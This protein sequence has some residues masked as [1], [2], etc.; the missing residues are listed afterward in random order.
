MN[1]LPKSRDDS[2]QVSIRSYYHPDYWS[3]YNEAQTKEKRL[4]YILLRELCDTIIEPV[5][6]N[7]RKPISVSD[8]IFCMGLK[9]YNNVSSRRVS[10]DL[11]HAQLSGFISRTPH[12]NTLMS[13]MNNKIAEELLQRLITLSA[14]P[15]KSL[16]TDFAVD[17]TGFS[18]QRYARWYQFRFK[19]GNKIT[20]ISPLKTKKMWVK[21]HVCVGTKT[22]IIT[23]AVVTFDNGADS[24]QLPKL[25]DGLQEEFNIRRVSA[26]KAYSSRKNLQLVQ[27]LN[28][29]PFIP[30]KSNAS[31][32]SKGCDLWTT[33][34]TYF[35]QERKEFDKYYHRRSNVETTFSMI[36]TKFG[37]FLR[38]RNNQGQI[39][40]VLLK[41]L[42]LNITCLIAEIFQNNVD[43]NFKKIED[44]RKK[45]KEKTYIIE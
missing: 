13:F 30:F 31:P 39:N 34:L 1:N 8:M 25:L 36:K 3:R 42:V 45:R 16:E 33:M 7:G 20:P 24:P 4:F 17:S 38:C 15:L 9:I 23:K 11:R 19:D 12:F 27:S 5:H 35:K 40:E 2:E 29:T 26:D 43:I 41:C 14:I 32:S 37:E 10:S 22:N 28:A 18:T 21:L 44:D 6:N